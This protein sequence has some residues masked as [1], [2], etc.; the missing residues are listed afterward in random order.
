MKYFL[1]FCRIDKD[2]SSNKYERFCQ[3]HCY[4][5]T[6]F[7]YSNK[8]FCVTAFASEIY[9][10]LLDTILLPLLRKSN[11]MRKVFFIG[12]LWREGMM[13]WVCFLSA[14]DSLFTN[15]V[16]WLMFLNVAFFEILFDVVDWNTSIKLL[17]RN[18]NR[19]AIGFLCFSTSI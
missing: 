8:D 5:Q 9:I 6:S 4:Q 2:N 19:F 7:F 10:I 13:L 16:K 17:N 18:L 11:T 12:F 14:I 3:K 15:F 1:C